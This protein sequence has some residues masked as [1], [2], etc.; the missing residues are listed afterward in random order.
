MESSQHVET[1]SQD[2]Q[3]LF[4]RHLVKTIFRA[5]LWLGA[6]AL[7]THFYP[8]ARWQWY[9]AFAFTG[10]ALAFS[11]FVLFGAAISARLEMQHAKAGSA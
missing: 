11:L 1:T 10:I 7:V 9:V 6:A 3:R 4:Y 5:A 2:L 8:D